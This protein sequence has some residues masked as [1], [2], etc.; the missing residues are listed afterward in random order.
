MAQRQLPQLPAASIV[1]D[2]DIAG[3]LRQ[4]GIDYRY[5][6][7]QMRAGLLRAGNNLSDV[8]NPALARQNLGVVDASNAA[9]KI[10]END[11]AYNIQRHMQIIN[12][13]EK[14]YDAG[15]I[16]GPVT[17]NLELGS[18]QKGTV[19]GSTTISISGVAAA[20][21]VSSV[22]L[23]IVN[24]GAFSVNYG[25]SVI[26]PNMTPPTFTANG[27]DIVLFYTFNGGTSWYGILA[28]A[29]VG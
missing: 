12:Y 20:G 11:F 22:I 29:N 28:A 27:T 25:A 17:I 4:G 8:P 21:Q 18:L 7:S 26:W 19:T 15:N 16:S 1:N 6:A 13:S 10:A 2:A 3:P 24:G 14:F 5:T 23:H 9:S